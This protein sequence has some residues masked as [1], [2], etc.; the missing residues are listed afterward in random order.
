MWRPSLS[1][2]FG[3]DEAAAGHATTSASTTTKTCNRRDIY[4]GMVGSMGLRDTDTERG[5]RKAITID[6]VGMHRI[7]APCIAHGGR[8]GHA[9]A[10]HDDGRPLDACL[11]RMVPPVGAGRS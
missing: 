11:G 2:I 9:R 4:R 1:T 7:L 6:Q 5:G 3:N 10:R 8:M